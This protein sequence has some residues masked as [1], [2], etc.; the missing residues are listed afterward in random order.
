MSPTVLDERVDATAPV[1]PSVRQYIHDLAARHGV[2]Y[3]QTAL[4]QLSDAYA[5]LSDSDVE[6]DETENLITALRRAK[7]ISDDE[8][9]DLHDAY[10]RGDLGLS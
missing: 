8:G 1:Y 9:S 7:V 5:R 3:Q 2:I 4:D 10:I 6:L